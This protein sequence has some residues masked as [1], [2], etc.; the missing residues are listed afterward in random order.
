MADVKDPNLRLTLLQA[1]WD[2]GALPPFDKQAFYQNTLGEPYDPKADY[3]ERI[4][5]RVRDALLATPMPDDVLERL[6]VVAWDG[7]NDVHHFVWTNWD[8]ES[9]E[10]D[11]AD[12]TGIEKCKNLERLLFIAGARFTDCKPLT[13][14]SKLRDVM[15]HGTKLFDLRPLSTLPALD[16]LE[17]AFAATDENRA[18]VEILRNRGVTLETW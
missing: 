18:V 13:G 8:G 1:A 11:V 9:D 17:V 6:K 12:L 3:N 4:D 14:M 15:I 2:A 7:G 10:F 16:K 5:K